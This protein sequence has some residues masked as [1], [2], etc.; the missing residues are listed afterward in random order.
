MG[1]VI[2]IV[3]KVQ[4]ITDL[5][6]YLESRLGRN[7]EDGFMILAVENSSITFYFRDYIYAITFQYGIGCVLTVE[8]G[9]SDS[10]IKKV[11]NVIAPL[12]WTK[13][14]SEKAPRWYCGPLCS[15]ECEDGRKIIEWELYNPIQ[16]IKDFAFMKYMDDRELKDLKIYYPNTKLEDFKKDVLYGNYTGFMD[17]EKVRKYDSLS[18]IELYFA[19]INCSKEYEK[20]KEAG[21]LLGVNVDAKLEDLDFEL[22]YLLRKTEKFGITSYNPDTYPLDLTEE[23]EA[24]VQWWQ[25]GMVELVEKNPNAINEWNKKLKKGIDL[26]F[27][28]SKDYNDYLLK[29]KCNRREMEKE[30]I[31]LDEFAEKM[32]NDF[33]DE[34][35]TDFTVTESYEE[36]PGEE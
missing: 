26:N 18:E 31:G 6:D 30:P 21:N 2:D 20:V 11:K 9:A 8:E 12:M 28:P 17:D 22:S 36:E 7:Y 32:K 15:Y 35:G 13:E 34:Y 3:G 24:W 25:D 14:K 29:V 16:R 4:K 33:G 1:E 5:R 19:I 10:G 23:Q 27:K